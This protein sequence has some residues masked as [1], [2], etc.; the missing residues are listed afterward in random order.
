MLQIPL[1]IVGRL[2]EILKETMK[3]QKE[4]MLEKLEIIGKETRKKTNNIY[5]K[6]DKSKQ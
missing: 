5:A 3:E 4:K 1:L 2:T 6:K